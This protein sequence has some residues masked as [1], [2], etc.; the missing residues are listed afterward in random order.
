MNL[1]T[2]IL[3]ISEGVRVIG[4]D[5]H[6]WSHNRRDH[7]DGF[8][9]VIVDL[10]Q[11]IANPKQPARLLDVV[12][13]RSAD[14]LRLWL[15]Q[16]D[17]YFRNQVRIVSRDGFQ[18]YATASKQ[19][20]PHARR[21]MDPFHLV[22]LA[23]DKLTTLRQR[24]QQEKYH[25]R[26]RKDDPLYKNRKTLLTSQRWLTPTQL[27]R[28]EDWFAADG[29][30]IRLQLAWQVYQAVIDCYNDTNKRRAKTKMREIIDQCRLLPR[31]IHPELAQLG[32]SLH[33]RQSDVLAY[34]DVGV[35]NGPVEA[36]NGRL[37]HLRGIA[38]GFRNLNHYIL[39]CLIHSGQLTDKITAL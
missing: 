33:K 27:T 18:G 3:T 23:A 20:L 29:D 6:K 26:G 14:A 11:H 28:L 21:V 15:N 37:E 7:G 30:N 13:G 25:R 4:V 32:R 17:Q 2:T 5:E 35:S 16:R 9:T 8:V 24:M 22:R 36:I 38:L 34:F 10:T 31:K 12:E 39:R 1:S 19:L